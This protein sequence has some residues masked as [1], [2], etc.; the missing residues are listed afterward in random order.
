VPDLVVN[1]ENLRALASNLGTVHRTLSGAESDSQDLAG[2]I[3]HARLASTV[4]SFTDDWDR[5]RKDLTEQV[6]TL[7]ETAAGVADAFEGT[8]GQLADKVLERD[9]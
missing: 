9:S 4:Q 8:D 1:T 6:G 2:M 3:P 7:K 5:R